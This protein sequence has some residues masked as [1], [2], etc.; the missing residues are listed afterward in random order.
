MRKAIVVLCA[1]LF[2]VACF[3]GAAPEPPPLVEPKPWSADQ[4]EPTSVQKWAAAMQPGPVVGFFD[5]LFNRVGVRVTDTGEAFTCVHA[6][7]RILFSDELDPDS[8]DFTVEIDSA[9][10]DRM[11]SYMAKGELDD[12]AQFRI[13]S[14]ISTPATRAM[15]SRPI[16]RSEWLRSVLYWIGNAPERMQVVLTGPPGESPIGHVIERV[17]TE[18]KVIAG[19]QED[20]TALYRLTVPD[21]VDFQRRMI[22]ARRDNSL[23]N[24]IGF[25]RWYGAFTDRVAVPA[26]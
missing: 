16:I 1:S 17:G 11:L 3:G 4:G 19:I 22:A 13:M 8:V 9:Q 15:L 21:A 10:V 25:A 2:A 6:G 14:V 18:V 24:W 7:D 26:A 23:W 12:V 5:G 20:I